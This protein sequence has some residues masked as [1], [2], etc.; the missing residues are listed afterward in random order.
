MNNVENHQLTIP[1]VSGCLIGS[2][3]PYRIAMKDISEYLHS[4]NLHL[5]DEN[6]DVWVVTPSRL[7]NKETRKLNNELGLHKVNKYGNRMA[8]FK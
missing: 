2:D 7:F 4:Q 5:A 1:R 3:I 6:G 8:R